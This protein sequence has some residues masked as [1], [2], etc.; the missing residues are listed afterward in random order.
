MIPTK[1]Y[2]LKTTDPRSV[3]Y[4]KDVADSC[5][6]IGLQWEYLDWYQGKPDEAWK[7]TGV[8]KPPKV[9]GNAAAQC[10][11]SGHIAIWKKILD[12]G[13][14]GIVLEHDGMMLHPVNIDIPDNTIVVLG[15]K[16]ANPNE[17]DHDAAGLPKEIID[18]NGGGHE[19]SHAYAITPATADA[20]LKE[21]ASQGA[22]GA[23]DNRYF[24]KSRKTEIKIKIMS[25]TPA[26]GWIRESTIQKKSSTKNYEFIESFKQ[27]HSTAKTSEPPKAKPAPPKPAPRR[28]VNREFLENHEGYLQAKREIWNN[29]RKERIKQARAER[30]KK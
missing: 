11:F 25:P 23:I 19:G 20:L 7:N 13:E 4:A 10:C 8:P 12:S 21:I 6:K 16:L 14:A 15:Y 5:D 28:V 27:Y 26:I 30:Q 2:I 29:P 18:V 1:A 17:Y 22:V 3:V 24:L 9:T